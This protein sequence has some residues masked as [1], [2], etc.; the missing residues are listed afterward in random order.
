MAM[1]KTST[2]FPE[3]F[4]KKQFYF[5]F[6]FIMIISTITVQAANYS[7]VSATCETIEN[8][9][10]HSPSP[11]ENLTVQI[12]AYVYPN[13]Y[14]ISCNGFRDG[15]I[16]V[17]VSGGTMPYTF[18]W[19]TGDTT[20]NLTN[21]GAGLYILD[22]IDADSNIVG[23]RI[24]L[25]EPESLPRLRADGEIF[26]YPN[27]YH[28][29]CINCFNGSISLSVEG[30]TGSYN[31]EWRDGPTTQN[32]S[33]LGRGEY[34]VFVTDQSV[35]MQGENV[36]LVFALQEPP[37]TTWGLTGNAGTDPGTHFMGTVDNNDFVFRTNNAERLRIKSA[38]NV[39]IGTANPTEKLHISGNSI[40]SQNL[41]IGND[42]TVG[43][44]F[45]IDSL[46]G[47]GFKFDS[48]SNNSYKLV[49]VDKFGQLS[50]KIDNDYIDKPGQPCLTQHYMPWLLGGNYLTEF[51]NPEY[52]FIGTCNRYP[53]RIFTDASERM[54][55][56]AD[57]FVGIGTFEPQQMLEVRNGSIL[58][59]GENS[60]VFFHQAFGEYV[61][62]NQVGD[63]GNYGIEYLPP[64]TQNHTK[65]GLNFWR[66]AGNEY[67][68]QTENFV[69]HLA[70]DGNVGIGTGNPMA[71]VH[72]KHTE[73][74]PE[75]WSFAF[76][77]DVPDDNSAFYIDNPT[78]AFT[79]RQFND[80][81][82]FR[83][84]GNGVVNAKTIYAEAVKVKPPIPPVVGYYYWPDFVFNK[85]YKL[86]SLAELEQFIQL[87]KHLPDVP[88]QSQVEEE[89][90]DLFELNSLLLKKIEELTLYVI[91]L[92]K[93]VEMLK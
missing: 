9:A 68:E 83:V 73:L 4:F 58:V 28:V 76:I 86:M 46:A 42:L 51:D 2:S 10:L 65:G 80:T 33:G 89:G 7:H 12:S 78:K 25:T 57:G 43:G 20:Q 35:C 11:Q 23:G 72:I 3:L 36:R 19:S 8:I 53:F 55:I 37:A 84:W 54:R 18:L 14:N 92:Q 88:T 16:N 27:G 21:V 93:Q 63:Y 13:G 91:D 82:I 75:G 41:S 69:L 45:K 32:R 79:I 30:G 62:P 47:E 49:F 87:N 52:N 26:T 24:T 29:S 77:L 15:T 40:I 38:G 71:K 61:P 48:L 44:I 66:P 34:T 22:V 74:I 81:E 31:F 60:G 67:N 85:D 50:T 17:V 39:G 5:I 90:I 6:A 59:S 1:K 64:N 56:T 70:D